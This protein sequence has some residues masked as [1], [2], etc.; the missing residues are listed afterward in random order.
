MLSFV[1]IFTK[2]TKFCYFKDSKSSNIFNDIKKISS[3]NN[4]NIVSA[5]QTMKK[6][7][8]VN[9]QRVL[10]HVQYSRALLTG[11]CDKLIIAVSAHL[12]LTVKWLHNN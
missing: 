6:A 3:T 5:T 4:L 12:D 9:V 7:L 10:K 8:S 1:E 2:V 11:P